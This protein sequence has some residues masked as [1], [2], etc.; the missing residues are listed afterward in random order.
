MAIRAE[1]SERWDTVLSEL[2]DEQR[3]LL[4][5]VADDVVNGIKYRRAAERI[6]PNGALEI[7]FS[8]G[9]A[10]NSQK[11]EPKDE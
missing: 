5:D 9:C 8:I 2:D 10:I 6:G 3:R 11:G 4:M 7:L 1:V